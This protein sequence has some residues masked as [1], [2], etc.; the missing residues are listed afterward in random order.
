MSASALVPEAAAVP[1][2]YDPFAD[3][4]LSRVV[5]TTEPQREVWLADR[6]GRD[7]SLAFNESVSLRLHGKLDTAFLRRALQEL[8]VRRD[9]L[10]ASFGPDG[11][12]LCVREQI[13]L[14]LPLRDLSSLD[15][16][17]SQAA[18][19]TY[20][21]RAVNT[22]FALERDALF[23]AEL[24]KLAPD[25][26]LLL[27][28]AHHIVCDGWSWW[29]IVRELG[30]LYARARGDAG[31]PIPAPRSFADYA[32]AQ[33][34]SPQVGAHGDD[35]A[36]WLARFADGA[37]VLELP[38]D[39]ARPA[40]R[41]FVSAR[42][43]YT[44]DVE[45]V[46][47]IR[48][49]GAR[50][51][52]SLFATL[53][54]GF[55]A[56]MSRLA[57]QS[58]VVVGIPAAG[59]SVD[60]NEDLVGH[61][62]NLLPLSIDIAAQKAFAHALDS[63]QQV[64]LDAL[65]HQ[66]YTFGTLLKKL[67]I[68]RDPSRLPLVSVMFN[69]DQAL[70]HESCSF[71][72][73]SLEFSCNPRSHEN[74]ELFVN[75]VQVDGALRLECQ[76]NKDLFDART[77]LRWMSAFECLL[78]AASIR[79]EECL[80]R[81]PLVDGEARV[82]L[83][84]LQP[85]A[86]VAPID[87]LMHEWFEAQC[88]RTP[89]RIAV[90]HRKAD[91][92]YA[93]L[94]SRANRIADILRRRGV[95][96][97]ALVGIALDRGVDM[98]AALLGILKAGAGYVPLDPQFPADRLAYMAGDAGLA[99]LVTLRAHAGQFDLRGRP[100]LMLD[101]LDAEL[102]SASATRVVGAR[103]SATP[104]SPAY[105]IYTSGSTGRPKG[106]QIP[107]RAVAN[108]IAAMQCEPGIDVEDR[109]LAVTTL[110]FD[111][112]VLELMLPLSVGA[113]VVLADSD[114][115]NDGVALQAL[116]ESSRAT[117]MQ[118]TPAT[119][120][121]LLD[122]GWSGS[123]RLKA[124]CGGEALS[125]ALASQMLPRCASLWNM[126]GPT[127]T[128][129]WSTC[130]RI[131]V[132][133]E[134]GTPDIHIGRPIANTR[135]WVLDDQ[136]ELCPLGVPGEICI[137]G[138]GV[139]LGYLQRPEKTAERFIRDRHGPANDMP[140]CVD[141]AM[142]TLY[143]TGDRGRWRADGQL[144]HLGRLDF[145]VKVRGYR[146]ELG[147]IEANLTSHPC[148]THAV[149][150]TREDRPGDV[151]LVA[152]VVAGATV[153][154]EELLAYL[155]LTLP[156]YM[157]PQHVV[158][159][160]SLPSLPNGK[161]DRA[162]L[163]A[164]NQLPSTRGGESPRNATE[165]HIERAMAQ[166]LGVPS[167]SIDDDFFAIGGHS[168]L[169]AQL[170]SRL[171]RELGGAL[172]LRSLFDSPTVAKL[173]VALGDTT[174]TADTVARRAIPRRADQR[175]APLSLMQER[176]R[177]IEEFSPGQLG[178]NTPSAHRLVGALDAR[179][180]DRAF[181]EL[182]K[183]QT[184]LRTSIGMVEGEP[185]QIVHD[186]IQTGL[187]QVQDLSVLPRALR[188]IEL[189]ERL[190]ALVM[191]PFT[192][193]ERAP[194]FVARLFKLD[195]REHV[196]FFMPHHM[197]WDGWSFDLL[198]SDLSEIYTG[199]VEGRAPS[200]PDL[201]VTYGDFAAWHRDWMQGPEY[202]SQLAF[203]REHL[204]RREPGQEPPRAIATDKPRRP[205]MSGRSKS[206]DVV[207][208][209]EL[210]HTLHALG[211]DFDATVFVIL[212]SAYFALLER[213]SGQR[214]LIVGSPLRG[215]NVAEVEGLMGYFT[216]LMPLRLHVDTSQS[217]ASL[218][219][220]VKELVLDS[221]AHPDVR[222]EDLTREL[223]LPSEGGGSL[224]YQSLF[225]FQDTRQRSVRW[226]DLAHSRVEVFQ[227]GATED[228]GLWFIES[229]SGISGGLIYNADIF[230]DETAELLCDRYLRLLM[231]VAEDSARSLDVLT[232]FG[233]GRPER[234]GQS[235]ALDTKDSPVPGLMPEHMRDP[236]MP[237]EVA[238]TLSES[239]LSATTDSRECYLMGMWE[240]LLGT[241]IEPGDN[242]FDLG[243][244]SML[245]VTM[246]SRVVRD[247]GVR[248]E[249]VRLASHSLAQIAADLPVRDRPKSATSSPVATP[250]RGKSIAAAP[251]DADTV[252]RWEP[253]W[254]GPESRR[255]YAALHR[256]PSGAQSRLGVLLAPPLLHELP[257]SRR[258]VTEVAAQ[259][260]SHGFPCMRFDYFGTG[261]SDGTGDEATFA[262][263]REDLGVA[264]EALRQSSAV[265]R[266]VVLALRG[267]ALPVSSWLEHGAEV[268]LLV[269][270]EPIVDGSAWLAALEREHAEELRSIDRYP[271]RH[272][273]PVSADAAELMGLEV[274][275]ALRR[276]LA[277][278]NL[279][280][281]GWLS[282]ANTWSLVRAH[283]GASS[284]PVGKVFDWPEEMSS[285]GASTRMD[286]ALFISPGVRPVIDAIARALAD[287]GAPDSGAP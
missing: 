23:R 22:P 17:A 150:V 286:S 2:D 85:Q 233:D 256:A 62:V 206:R 95:H 20:L 142:P 1:V 255:R 99:A 278:T 282:P 222:L 141:R 53:L 165:R 191:T 108:F 174:G 87:R 129:V 67:R 123:P 163:P 89:D 173:A 135:V 178:Y 227:P 194:L 156:D 245:A 93:A 220:S 91:I 187:L 119:W 68:V 9:V 264:A 275:P 224:L 104:E 254:I 37:P 217:F 144:Q 202:A 64:L 248:L 265:D 169:A 155:R 164:P 240:E 147:E 249:L 124:L 96:R 180:L 192:D 172:T 161:L 231:A 196:L 114:V 205:G 197:I 58:R 281:C 252:G 167:V 209:R 263:M 234:I 162:A 214:D 133:P 280:D 218:V 134:D 110:S 83:A 204:G 276:D 16:A 219:R 40:R 34:L 177:L 29:V 56:L 198:Y 7:A 229:E 126:Y 81:L 237:G 49:M 61:C 31:E 146:I 223:S 238:G 225:S 39:R 60:G 170:T 97:G 246:A 260:A 166:V 274:S 168:L 111:I 54:T 125:P 193:F 154:A 50:R 201:P 285:F 149:V 271:L 250:P 259:L 120:R 35:E 272:G 74:F 176:L 279:L 106:V 140:T 69:I 98:L 179:L 105:V 267:G 145:Q 103:D 122:A 157:I 76:Y 131:E 5:P 243:G 45:L 41:S 6:L 139:A 215:R 203:W 253:L 211:R 15:A 148:V 30:A 32:L 88:D 63:T 160:D 51:G 70:D 235:L 186:E 239:L 210:T 266:I 33:A 79:P 101:E 277:A 27:L 44:L 257:R 71:P 190:H 19:A 25:E 80:A 228:L 8:L 232:R 182:A 42:E 181:R 36:Y 261:D 12:T 109:L 92:T 118:A 247:T 102:A 189:G 213:M 185:V 283:T 270:W 226:G 171:N 183:R 241:A 43:D 113:L 48:R 273:A 46:A 284:L 10:R 47:A 251:V 143:R 107:H 65:E 66:R 175:T 130:A 153:E 216:N 136:G 86:V 158:I 3:G 207:I 200:L 208:P 82:E 242:F 24:L 262:T 14:P 115:S 77:I 55:S 132:P 72:G 28:T 152:Y 195:A 127:E 21:N 269:L 230:H 75:A 84:G 128:T 73:L 59:Q 159:L 268:E 236:E 151:R 4:V 221:L 94:E 117:M 199:L 100:V 90:L 287:L 18:V 26:H 212:L 13:D 184:V 57:A 116:L 244:N 121:L 52:S 258:L 137:G 11:E 78:R 112:A 138:L 38:S 188:E